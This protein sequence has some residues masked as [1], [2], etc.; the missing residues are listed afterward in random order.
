MDEWVHVA[1]VMTFEPKPSHALY[2]YSSPG[3]VHDNI[4]GHVPVDC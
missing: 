1:I 3:S 4:L 2:C